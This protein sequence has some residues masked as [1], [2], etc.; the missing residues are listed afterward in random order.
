MKVKTGMYIRSLPD[1]GGK[2]QDFSF[3]CF[4]PSQDTEHSLHSDHSNN[5][6]GQLF[7]LVNN[8]RCRSTWPIQ[9]GNYYP[10]LSVSPIIINII[11]TV[12][13]LSKRE[14]LHLNQTQTICTMAEI[15]TSKYLT[16]DC[17]GRAPLIQHLPLV[18]PV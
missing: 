13:I 12:Y 7:I 1:I 2:T 6:G 16:L 9:S 11:D 14:A 5:T 8:L 3:D 18:P 10:S 17:C 15:G 4:P